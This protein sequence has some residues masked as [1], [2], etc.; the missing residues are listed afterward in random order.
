MYLV[1]AL[2]F[3]KVKLYKIEF[4]INTDLNARYYYNF[5]LHLKKKESKS[6]SWKKKTMIYELYLHVTFH[7]V[8]SMAASIS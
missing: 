8:K 7:C 1:C 5:I 6:F 3:T 2:L 4:V